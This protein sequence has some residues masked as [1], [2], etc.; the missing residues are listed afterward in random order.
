AEALLR[1]YRSRDTEVVPR[2]SGAFAFALWDARRERLLL[3]RDRMGE[4]PLY[5]H[6]SDNG[7]IWA[8]EAKTLLIAP[9]VDRRVNP[10]ALH[11]YLSL[12][13]TP[14]PLTIFESISQLPPAHKLV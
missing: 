2:L 13:Y 10:R 11:H 1:A 6:D 4:K 7:L 3:A 9:W 8:S 5:W 12:Q 14:N